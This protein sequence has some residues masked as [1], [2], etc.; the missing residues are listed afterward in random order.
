MNRKFNQNRIQRS[1]WKCKWNASH[2][3]STNQS[4]HSFMNNDQ[5]T[6]SE[7]QDLIFIAKLEKETK[8]LKDFSEQQKKFYFISWVLLCLSIFSERMIIQVTLDTPKT[9]TC[10]F[11]SINNACVHSKNRFV[12]PPSNNL[13]KWNKIG[14]SK[15]PLVQDDQFLA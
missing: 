12:I 15:H 14:N 10:V 1:I 8:L 3:S 6:Q 11:P 2:W 13:S 9:L 5:F 7:M 4:L